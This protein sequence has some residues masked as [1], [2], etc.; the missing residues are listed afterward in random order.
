[1]CSSRVAEL[2]AGAG[3]HVAPAQQCST[4]AVMP[5]SSS[6]AEEQQ[7]WWPLHTCPCAAPA[8]H[9]QQLVHQHR[10]SSG[11]Q[12]AW[13][14]IRLGHR[15]HHDGAGQGQQGVTGPLHLGGSSQDLLGQAV[16]PAG[17]DTGG[18]QAIAPLLGHVCHISDDDCTLSCN[19]S[20]YTI[21]H[22][23]CCTWPGR[24]LF[25]SRAATTQPRCRSAC[26]PPPT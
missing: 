6:S 21:M 13:V 12:V 24:P 3:Q 5:S 1:M 18:C 2:L 16:M 19:H 20:S 17:V 4:Q 26:C 7:R 15:Q 8:P 11:G 25:Q 10:S 22:T 14:G 23:S 9:L